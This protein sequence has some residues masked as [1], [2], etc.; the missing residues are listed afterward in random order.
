MPKHFLWSTIK[1]RLN[2]FEMAKEKNITYACK[3]FGISRKTFYK[4]YK[5]YQ[6]SDGDPKSLQDKSRRPRTHPKLTSPEVASLIVKIRKE[7]SFGPRRLQ[8]YL[9][10]DYGIALSLCGIW[11]VLNRAGLILR[12]KRRRKHYQSYGEYVHYPGHKVQID[13]KPL[14]RRQG[15]FDSRDYQYV[16]KDVF[17]KLRF[18]KVYE[19]LSVNNSVD[20]AWRTI[21]FF[22]FRIKRIQTDHGTEFTY[23]ML[24]SKRIHPLDKLLREQ[25]IKHVLSPVATPRYN[26]QVERSIRTDLEEFYRP[27]GIVKDHATLSK[28]LLSYLEY[29]NQ[30]RPHMAINMLTPLQKLHSTPGFENAKLNWRCYL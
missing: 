14:P 20:F 24:S 27:L 7:T 4:W 19:E 21:R 6:E 9:T 15:Q 10:R 22:P 13:T 28:K 3:Y 2:W 18:I 1:T 30:L 16:A 26:G 5:R 29:Y 12:Y 25:K 8:F 17:T 11:K 23:D